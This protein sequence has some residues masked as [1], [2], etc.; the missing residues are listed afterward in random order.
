MKLMRLSPLAQRL[1]R[2]ARA[3]AAG[4]S[5]LA[6]YRQARQLLLAELQRVSPRKLDDTHRRA[7]IAS[8]V[9]HSGMG[10]GRV[11]TMVGAV[12]SGHS[13][14]RPQ[15]RWLVGALGVLVAALWVLLRA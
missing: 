2:V 15:L 1:R 14:S 7:E 12:S 5:T 11:V 8:T 3:H 4:E 10:M 9:A 13:R 6:E